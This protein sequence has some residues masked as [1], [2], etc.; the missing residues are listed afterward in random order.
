MF[1][2]GKEPSG[3]ERLELG[4]RGRNGRRAI[5]QVGKRGDEISK[6]GS[7]TGGQARACTRF[8]GLGTAA[9]SPQKP[10]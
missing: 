2:A 6:Y 8:W 1:A 4:K 3:R 5:P 10:V 7:T 9:H